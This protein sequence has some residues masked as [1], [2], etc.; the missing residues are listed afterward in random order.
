MKPQRHRRGSRDGP[1]SSQPRGQWAHPARGA[2]GRL[3]TP[4]SKPGPGSRCHSNANVP[5]HKAQEP[6]SPGAWLPVRSGP[7]PRS[8]LQPAPAAVLGTLPAAL[9]LFNSPSLLPSAQGFQS[10][11][12]TPAGSATPP[13][14]AQAGRGAAAERPSTP[15]AT[16]AA[17]SPSGHLVPA[18]PPV[19]HKSLRPSE[20]QEQP[21]GVG[22]KQ[23][24]KCQQVQGRKSSPH[25][26]AGTARGVLRHQEA[27][28]S[29]TQDS[30]R[31]PDCG[32]ATTDL[33]QSS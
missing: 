33:A 18:F 25:L 22:R 10:R 28:L 4:H 9:G 23:R 14:P 21:P 15:P 13:G 3:P 7:L 16:T 19:S 29:S 24:R 6:N 32:I 27:K 17:A 26:P 30:T 1:R 5:V 12:V 31:T 11:D 2:Q 20:K 8:C